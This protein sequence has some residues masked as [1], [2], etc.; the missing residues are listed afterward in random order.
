MASAASVTHNPRSRRVLFSFASDTKP[1]E[2]GKKKKKSDLGTPC[3]PLKLPGPF[4]S[5]S[6]REKTTLTHRLCSVL[7]LHFGK[8]QPVFTVWP[9]SCPA[10]PITTREGA[11]PPGGGMLHLPRTDHGPAGRP[12]GG[13]KR[14]AKPA[15]RE[16][17]REGS[18]Q[19]PAAPQLSTRGKPQ[20]T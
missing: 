5:C 12:T 4:E 18:G 20:E 11:G 9:S 7:N 19:G 14:P 3:Q 10:F 8:S 17:R 15:G 2:K 1:Q 16:G 13:R 6:V